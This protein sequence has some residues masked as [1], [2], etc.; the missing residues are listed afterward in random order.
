MEVNLAQDLERFRVE[1]EKIP[2]STIGFH[3]SAF[4]KALPDHSTAL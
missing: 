2:S 3:A 1:R 4:E